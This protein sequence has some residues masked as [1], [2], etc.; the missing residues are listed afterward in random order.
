MIGEAV[1]ATLATVGACVIG[2]AVL[3]EIGFVIGNVPGAVIGMLAGC[4]LFGG[5]VGNAIINNGPIDPFS[6]GL[7]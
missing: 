6:V 4:L 5:H 3:G 7:D 2:G 1:F